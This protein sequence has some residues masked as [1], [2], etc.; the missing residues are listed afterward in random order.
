MIT[1]F[2]GM[3]GRD[4]VM[5]ARPAGEAGPSGPEAQEEMH[6]MSEEEMTEL[7][8]VFK[9]FDKDGDGTI[10]VE[11]LGTALRSLGQN[12]TKEEVRKLIDETDKDGS[13]CIEFDE[14]AKMMAQRSASN[15]TSEQ[16]LLEA[17]KVFDVEKTGV[18]TIKEVKH[19]LGTIGMELNAEELDDMMAAGD[20]DGNG[21]INFED[22]KLLW[23]GKEHDSL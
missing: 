1:P 11:E 6:G 22:F 7:K 2:L 23:L 10:D 21:T 12:P 20:A 13:G 18:I 16:E 5:E 14:F 15:Q 19:V 9:T 8:A 4:T 3:Y 17:F